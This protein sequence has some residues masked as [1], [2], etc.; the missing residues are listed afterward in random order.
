MKKIVYIGGLLALPSIVAAQT[1][2]NVLTTVK[3]LLNQVIPIVITL[4][5]IYFFYGV[6]KYVMAAGDEEAQTAGRSIMI[7]GIIGLV[8]I[9]GIW[10]LVGIIANTFGISTG[11]TATLPTI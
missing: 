4:A 9:V 10:G 1:I 3:T 7:Y 2:G 11:G 8:V 5:V 6:A